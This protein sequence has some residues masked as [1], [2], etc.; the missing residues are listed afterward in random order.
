MILFAKL[1]IQLNALLLPF[2]S[3]FLNFDKV[4]CIGNKLENITRCLKILRNAR[5][6]A[7]VCLKFPFFSLP[8]LIR[9]FGQKMRGKMALLRI[10]IYAVAN[11][12]SPKCYERKFFLS[13][14]F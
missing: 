6:N 11:C 14:N 13:V 7:Y 5:S 4:F 8:A 1:S 10:R 12:I 3:N 2:R 9:M